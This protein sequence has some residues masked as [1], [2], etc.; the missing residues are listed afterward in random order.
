MK[1]LRSIRSDNVPFR[2][3]NMFYIHC[4]KGMNTQYI[5]I[6]RP[7]ARQRVGKHVSVTIEGQPLLGNGPID[8]RSGQQ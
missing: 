4:V 3:K 2:K 7:I 6:C 5:V 1:L 8:A